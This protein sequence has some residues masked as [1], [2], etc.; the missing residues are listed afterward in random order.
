[1]RPL[2]RS[3]RIFSASATKSRSCGNF[4]ID[5]SISEYW[6]PQNSARLMIVGVLNAMSHWLV[7]TV[8]RHADQAA[9]LGFRLREFDFIGSKRSLGTPESSSFNTRGKS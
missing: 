1:M 6:S 3:Q 5:F 7:N 4:W 2:A 8:N 9:F